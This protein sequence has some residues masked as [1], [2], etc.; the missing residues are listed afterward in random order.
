MPV[1]E[2]VPGPET[3]PETVERALEVYRE[4]GF[5]PSAM[6]KILVAIQQ[7]YSHFSYAMSLP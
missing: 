2:V 7:N 3:A 5:E 6:K 4:L 1:L